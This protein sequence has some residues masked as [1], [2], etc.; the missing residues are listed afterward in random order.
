MNL[1]LDRRKIQVVEDAGLA[2]LQPARSTRSVP[3][4]DA[5]TLQAIRDYL[6]DTMPRHLL[7]PFVGAEARNSSVVGLLQDVIATARAHGTPLG[8]LPDDE[9]T[10]LA[11]FAATLGWGPAQP[12]LDDPRVNEVKIV[13]RTVLV[14]EA[15]KPFAEAPKPLRRSTKCWRARSIWP[16]CSGV[17][18]DQLNPQATV[19]VAHGT[20]VHI[21]IPPCT[22]DGVLISASV[23]AASAPG[24]STMSPFTVRSTTPSAAYCACWHKHSARF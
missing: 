1:R 21:S 19:P 6:R 18:L 20:R 24:I 13:N 9:P 15:R 11:L 3:R 12:Y 16:T 22:E 8:Q 10:L 17:R 4:F 5:A 14:Q 23:A 2:L 7:D